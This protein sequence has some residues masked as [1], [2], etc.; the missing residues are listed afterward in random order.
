MLA[1]QLETGGKKKKKKARK[2]IGRHLSLW[3]DLRER[4]REMN[5]VGW[6]RCLVCSFYPGE[7]PPP[8]H[9]H[10]PIPAHLRA[11]PDAGVLHNKHPDKAAF[12]LSFPSPIL[13]LRT[14][15][16]TELGIQMSV[17]GGGMSVTD[18]SGSGSQ[19]ELFPY[20]FY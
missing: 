10:P 16:E 3:D 4:E 5:R 1:A 11:H 17:L 8:L 12:C 14:T 15:M 19:S 6:I 2:T 18:C 7:A 20:S 9:P 13:L